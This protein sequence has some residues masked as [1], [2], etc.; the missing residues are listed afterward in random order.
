MEKMVF[1]AS[2]MMTSR[3]SPGDDAEKLERLYAA[4]RSGHRDVA[5]LAAALGGL[6]LFAGLLSLVGG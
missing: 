5:R 6:A 1:A 2:L 4:A 3:R